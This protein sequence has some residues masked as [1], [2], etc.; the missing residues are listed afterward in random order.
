MNKIFGLENANK[1]EAVLI[2]QMRKL[3]NDYYSEHLLN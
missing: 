3:K 2:R 1:N